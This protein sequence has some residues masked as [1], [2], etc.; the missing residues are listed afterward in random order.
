MS[1]QK[2]L[3]QNNVLWRILDDPEFLDVKNVLDNVMKER[4]RENLGLVRKRAELITVEHE[5]HLWKTGVLGEDTPDKLCDTVLFLLGI[6]LALHACD[7]HHDLRHDSAEKPSQLS[8]ERDPTIGK[9]CLVYREDTVTKTNDGGLSHLKKERKIVWVFPSE[10]VKRCPVRLVDKYVSLCP[11]VGKNKKANFYLHSLEKPNPAQWYGVQAIG[12]NSLGNIVKNMLKSANL[13]SYFTNHSLC[14]TSATRLFQAGVEDKI[15]HEITGHVSDAIN[16]YQETS[17]A[18]KHEVSSVLN[19]GKSDVK[20]PKTKKLKVG[21]KSPVPSLEFSV[22]DR[23]ERASGL[24]CLCKRESF[25]LEKATELSEMIN[26]IVSQR[27]SGKAKI[28]LE[29]EFSD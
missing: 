16:K 10:N 24:Q 26:H 9:R 12:K 17:V 27:K 14:R 25:K 2:Y 7:E 15:V 22:A 6:N 4:A 20:S 13:D 21:P 1:I 28:K 29:I 18:Q 5:E 11:P 8:F 23:S 3:N 19:S